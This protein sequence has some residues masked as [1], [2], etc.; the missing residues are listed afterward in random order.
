VGVSWM[1]WIIERER[2]NV[3]ESKAEATRCI[4]T[5]FE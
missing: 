3:Y 5:T 4:F 1:E 2:I